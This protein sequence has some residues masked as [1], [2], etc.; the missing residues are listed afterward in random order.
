MIEKMPIQEMKQAL[1]EFIKP[2]AELMPEK[3]LKSV[4]TMTIEGIF[5][6]ETAV[7]TEMAQ[8][9]RLEGSSVWAKAKRVYRFLGNRRYETSDLSEGLYQVGCRQIQAEGMK[10]M[11]V[12]ID[13]V[14]LEKPYTWELEGVSIVYKPIPPGKSKEKRLVQGYPAITATVVNSHVPVTTYAKWFSYTTKDFESQNRE[15]ELAIESTCKLYPQQ[16][17]CFLGDAGLDDQKIFQWVDKVR[18]QFIIRAYHLDR[19]VEVYNP[20]LD[21]WETEQLKDLVNPIHYTLRF[22][23]LFL[24]AGVSR[25]ATVDLGGFKVR[26]PGTQQQLWVLVSEGGMENAT[27]VLITN[28]PLET[29]SQMRQTFQDWRLRTRIEHGYRFDQ[30][31][32]L[33]VED[34]RVHTLDRMQRLFALILLAAQ[35]VFYLMH[36]WPPEAVLWIRQLGGKLNIPS[37]RDGPYLVLHGLSAIFKTAMTLSFAVSNPFPHEVFNCG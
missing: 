37:D 25:L 29:F 8:R 30:E 32:G 20:R 23:A 5:G 12:A 4:M 31:Q 17:V 36:S 22:Q 27:L 1:T 18:Q 9:V 19:I 35:F 21:R 15:I 13:P 16:E 3:R 33:D 28:I 26:L 10:R 2:V 7:I 24:H 14:N 6:G 34:M 11:I